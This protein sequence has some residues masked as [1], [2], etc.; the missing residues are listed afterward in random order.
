MKSFWFCPQ[1]GRSFAT[2]Y[3]PEELR[4]IKAGDSATET[5]GAYC[6]NGEHGALPMTFCGWWPEGLAEMRKRRKEFKPCKHEPTKGGDS[7]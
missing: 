1:C 6:G 3:S 2:R 4:G 7:K 5:A